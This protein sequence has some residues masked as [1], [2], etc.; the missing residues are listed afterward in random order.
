MTTPCLYSIVRYAPYADTEEFANVGV[1]ICAPKERYFDFRITKRNDSRVK[2]FFHDDCIF[3][4]AKDAFNRELTLA[5]YHASNIFSDKELAQFFRYFTAKKESIFHFSTTRVRMTHDPK[6]ELDSLYSHY[7]NHV[8][9]TKERREEVLA[10]ELKRS[11]ERIDGLKNAFR[12]DSIE[13]LF[14]KFTMPLVAKRAGIIKKAIKPL[15]FSQSEPGKMTEHCDLWVNRIKRAAEEELLNIDDVLF[16]VEGPKNATP[17][18]LKALDFIYKTMDKNEIN[19]WP[20]S[21]SEQTIKFAKEV[22]I[23]PPTNYGELT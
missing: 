12:N 4:V 1:V 14:T 21:D 16:T 13:G 11:I 20:V 18:Q 17:S 8:N 2:N 23:I 3:P 22:L 10:T 7:V 6:Q 5:K 19:H 9:Y 15:S